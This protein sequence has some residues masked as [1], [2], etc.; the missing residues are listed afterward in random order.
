MYKPER[1]IYLLYYRTDSVFLRKTKSLSHIKFWFQ[2]VKSKI[3]IGKERE[4]LSH[5]RQ[6]TNYEPDISYIVVLTKCAFIDKISLKIKLNT[7][8]KIYVQ[9]VEASNELRINL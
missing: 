6:T 4:N 8:C 2:K 1:S 5:L 9:Y 3:K 7:S